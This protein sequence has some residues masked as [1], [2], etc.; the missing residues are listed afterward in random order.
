[1]YATLQQAQSSNCLADHP[2][3]VD[4]A[5]PLSVI[6]QADN[7]QI[8]RGG[9]QVHNRGTSLARTNSVHEAGLTPVPGN[10]GER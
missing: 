9:M 2:V 1:M 7:G 8:E 10:R 4:S 3:S 5:K 6:R